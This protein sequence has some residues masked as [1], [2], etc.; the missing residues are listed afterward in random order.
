MQSNNRDCPVAGERWKHYKGD[1]YEIIAI[2]VHTETGEYFV[3]YRRDGAHPEVHAW[4]RPLHHF[5]EKVPF[6]SV[7][8]HYRHRYE[9][10]N[11]R[12]LPSKEANR[13]SEEVA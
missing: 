10:V 3:V 7:G 5:M 8:E 1:I 4:A 12:S 2:G 13:V 11:T 6:N 9:K